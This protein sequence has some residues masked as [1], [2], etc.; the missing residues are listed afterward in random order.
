MIEGKFGRNYAVLS[1]RKP[2][3][4]KPQIYGGPSSTIQ[5]NARACSKAAHEA[6]AAAAAAPSSK[7]QT[8]IRY[9][10]G[11]HQ[12]RN[13]PLTANDLYLDDWRPHADVPTAGH[14][15]VICEC[16]KFHP[17]A[18]VYYIFL[19]FCSAAY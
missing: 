5:S 18:Y 1:P 19:F 4:R 2:N 11:K 9:R 14:R 15:C 3:P 16:V 13:I 10:D 7:A 12:R 17:V 6:A 8:C